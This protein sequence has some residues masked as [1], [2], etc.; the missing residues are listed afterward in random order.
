MQELQGFYSV[1]TDHVNSNI[2]AC[3]D[4][5]AFTKHVPYARHC[6]KRLILTRTWE[7]GFCVYSHFTDEKTNAQSNA[8]ISPSSPYLGGVL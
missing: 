6:A 7:I 4:I 2:I 8:M 1:D 3:N 5:I